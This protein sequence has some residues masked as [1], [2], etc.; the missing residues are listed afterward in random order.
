[1][2]TLIADCG[3]TKTD[4]ALVNAAG[5]AEY[6]ASPGMNATIMSPVELKDKIRMALSGKI[7]ADGVGEVFSMPP[8]A[9]QPY[10][11]PV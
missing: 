4:W 5:D 3:S 10:S 8:D 11:A 1:M 2:M 7:D 6:F 9:V